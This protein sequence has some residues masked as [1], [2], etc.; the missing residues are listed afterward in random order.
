MVCGSARTH[1][2]AARTPPSTRTL[3]VG[4]QTSAE[5]GGLFFFCC[6]GEEEE[7][8]QNQHNTRVGEF[9]LDRV[10][11]RRGQGGGQLRLSVCGSF[12]VRVLRPQIARKSKVMG[13]KGG[14][15]ERVA[16]SRCGCW[17]ER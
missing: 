14:G 17:T 16:V 2:T 6:R 1:A 8:R 12:G 3:M 4:F 13:E 5:G 7:A 10:K 15:R 11:D 9:V